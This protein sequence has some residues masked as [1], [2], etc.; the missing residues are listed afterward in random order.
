MTASGRLQHQRLVSRQATAFVY[1]AGSR[2]FFTKR[3]SVNCCQGRESELVHRYQVRKQQ[4]ASVTVPRFE[5][6][7]AVP[8]GRCCRASRS[9]SG[10]SGP[11]PAV[12]PPKLGFVCTFGTRI[13]VDLF[14]I[15]LLSEL[16]LFPLGLGLGALFSFDVL[17]HTNW[18]DVEAVRDGVLYT[19]PFSAIFFSL[20]ILPI[21]AI[22]RLKRLTELTVR[23]VFGERSVLET[24]LFCM[25][26]GFGEEALFRGAI[27][28]LLDRYFGVLPVSVA[29][30]ALAFGA[31]HSANVAYF[32]LSSMAGAF[33]AI[34]FELAHH[35][36]AAP[37]ITHSL[38]D[39]VTILAIKFFAQP[40]DAPAPNIDANTAQPDEFKAGTKDPP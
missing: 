12:Q 36:L 20:D 17:Q 2:H 13:T 6:V 9:A 16:A 1:C 37:S 14:W 7:S 11:V 28:G 31:A 3:W 40:P 5:T 24:L 33:F 38:Y 25:A 21:P 35:N 32:V 22:K 34:Q 27:Q 18:T 10:E 30:S 23:K 8:S 26:A 29:V 4:S 15:G 39:W 19:F